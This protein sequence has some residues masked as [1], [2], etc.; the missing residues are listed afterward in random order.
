M[1]EFRLLGH[2]AV[3]VDGKPLTVPSRLGQSLLAYLLL[4]RSTPHR[5]EKLAGLFWPD[6][7]ETKARRSL[8]HELW[9]LRKALDASSPPASDV[10]LS[11]DL[12][13]GIDPQ[14]AYSLDVALFERAAAC[15][16]ADDLI[17]A[18]DVYQGDLLP[19]FYDEWVNV[20]RERLNA[21][22]EE[23]MERLLEQFSGERRWKETL[24]W[25][26][27]WIALGKSPEPAY[28]ALMLA[29][30]ALGNRS[31]VASVYERC[32]AALKDDLGVE[33]SEQTRALFERLSRGQDAQRT[34]TVSSPS[35]S[36]P[37]FVVKDE[38]VLAS[39]SSSFI[40]LP[41]SFDSLPPYKGLR[42]FEEADA[43]WFF[44]RER[45]I[46]T[47]VG[48]L[49]E[50]QWL[51]VVGASG[52]GKSSLVR[53][54]LIPALKGSTSSASGN[55]VGER[56]VVH[57]LTPTAHPLEALAVEL[58]RGV[59]S[60][61]ATTTLADDLARD[62]RALRIFNQ[63]RTGADERVLLVIDQFEE[64]FTLCREEQERQ[65][66]IE[67]LL[68]ATAPELDRP[69]NVAIAL[70]ADFYGHAA[71]YASLREAL[72]QRQECIGPMSAEEM[73]RAI[74]GP[75]ERAGCALEPGLVDLML[76]DVGDEPGGLPLLSHA[77]LET[78]KRRRGRGLTFEGYAECGGVRGAIAQTAETVLR[79]LSPSQ[80]AIAKE[81]FLQLTELGERTPDTRRR[82]SIQELESLSKDATAARQ[83]LNTLAEARLVTLGEGTAEVAHESLIREWPTL[84]E[85]LSQNREALRLHRRLGEAAQAWEKSN[86]DPSDLYRG[87]RLVQTLEWAKANEQEQSPLEREFL[88][89]AKQQQEHEE[90][91]RE[92]QR[93]RELQAAR[94]LAEAEA[95]RAEEQSRAAHRLQQR[96]VYLAGALVVAA[97]LAFAAL[98][99]AGRASQSEQVAV[100]QQAIAETERQ[101]AEE[102]RRTAFVRELSV[103]AV[104]NLSTDPER[105]I[106]L[107]LQA[108][109]ISTANG[110]PVMREAEEALHRAVQ[111]SRVQLTLRGHTAG[112]WDIAYSPDGKHLATASIDKTA[113][114]WDAITGQ[115][116]LT[117]PGH[118][119]IINAVAFSPDGARLATASSD[120]T[121]KVW[122]ATTGQEL[123]TLRGHTDIVRGIAV[124]PDGKR[125][126]TAS[127][128]KTAKV[129][130]ALTGQEL[131]TLVGHTGGVSSIAYSPDGTRLA[132]SSWSD[133]PEH[134]A[135][136]WDAASGKLLVTLVGHTNIVYDV[137]FS[138]DGRRVATSSLDKTVKIWDA[139]SGQ[140]L[141]TVLAHNGVV[142]VAF[143]PDGNRLATAISDGTA[144][145]WD[146]TTGELLESLAGHGSNVSA[147][148]FSPNGLRLATSSQDNTARVW[149]ISP[150]GSR[151]V[152]TL[153]A[154]EGTTWGVAYS[155]NGT[156][157]ATVGTDK[158]ARIWD[159]ATGQLVLSLSAHTNQVGGVAFS[160]DGR[161][162]ATLSLDQTA[163]V[164]DISTPLDKGGTSG[165]LMLSVSAPGYSQP[166]GL[167]VPFSPDGRW[168][169]TPSAGGTATVWEVATGQA[170]LTLCCH[171]RSYVLGIAFSPDGTRLATGGT[172]SLVR[173]WDI[174]R[175]KELFTL[176]GHT[177]AVWAVAYSP[178]GRRLA[179]ASLDGSAKLWDATNGHLLLTLLG[180][181]GGVF[182]L[183]FSPDGN[184]LVTASSDATAKVWDVSLQARGNEQPLTLYNPAVG[185]YDGLAFTPDGKR[186][187]A[188]AGDGAVRI[189]ALP[190]QDIVA[191]AKSRLTRA[192]T[193]D[194]CQ[195]YLHVEECPA[196]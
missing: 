78:W 71:Q 102:E 17:G 100:K 157:L 13:L 181:A 6:T 145:V 21:L 109:S 56:W 28:R 188:A 135:K 41:S 22:L 93:Q 69:I 79:L 154:H 44:G 1:L 61:T 62:A 73:R 37:T 155:P 125:V 50:H 86:R 144:K 172:D 174:A 162:V 159:A 39:S 81:V 36:L 82:V 92:A 107:A 120:R 3:S 32:V 129:W 70:R 66:F 170:V 142:G 165:K 171:T 150:A 47:F 29:H 136:I 166:L 146:V 42:Q 110:R 90:A 38:E 183:A 163:K 52:S 46:A 184:R 190:L 132:T 84:Q 4:T 53:A 130:D 176:S 140:L 122:D 89:A 101:T 57:V 30:S 117:M 194:E 180:H 186:L 149:D 40:L 152:L 191:I 123:L 19:D 141:L 35:P 196:E 74:E 88:D 97:V 96:A 164:W 192:L 72:S 127:L 87:A 153:A 103:N 85:W 99:L 121:A 138:L 55:G 20:E 48:H 43:Q 54:G 98:L 15:Q 80:Q 77:L 156:R 51:T 182:D 23:Q 134:T 12:C 167:R 24:P 169:A 94:R 33:P 10:L 2:F 178:D 168:I 58:T 147:V 177:G 111:A 108:V 179:T 195:K 7:S 34:P 161:R 59:E 160:P 64:L 31:R 75:A 60:A 105:S 119:D 16:T 11:D 8:R 68:R 27:R 104:N 126:A 151:E 83:V 18:L 175:D 189:Y 128:D 65:A 124:S 118:A 139:T 95:K 185:G 25:A 26:E 131:L 116:L 173:V 193:T 76:R 106:L 113:K 114:V 137:T 63:K 5:R 158:T 14:V 45:L 115:A 187:A 67:N 143:S 148:A 112:L 91:E 133:E 9:R 49:A